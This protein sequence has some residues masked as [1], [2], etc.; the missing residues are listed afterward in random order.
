MTL[1]AKSGLVRRRLGSSWDALYGG[2]CLCKKC[3]FSPKS[4]EGVAV[5]HAVSLR[6]G[7][8]APVSHGLRSLLEF[9]SHAVEF[10][11]GRVIFISQAWYDEWKRKT[12]QRRVPFN[13]GFCGSI[14]SRYCLVQTFY[15]H[16]RCIIT[17]R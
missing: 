4:R 7:S 3:Q 1:A 11:A 8:P 2:F 16:T 5:G 15:S 17:Q 13:G 14:G 10:A 12:G 9:F 6:I